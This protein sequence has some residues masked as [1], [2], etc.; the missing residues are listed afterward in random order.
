MKVDVK[1]ETTSRRG[2]HENEKGSFR[3]QE[4]EVRKDEEE[5]KDCLGPRVIRI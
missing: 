5:K 1:A 3:K 4:I 2:V